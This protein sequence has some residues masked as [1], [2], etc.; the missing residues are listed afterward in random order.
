MDARAEERLPDGI[1]R[2]GRELS[3]PSGEGEAERACGSAGVERDRPRRGVLHREGELGGERADARPH[4]S[5]PLSESD[6]ARV[7]ATQKAMDER[8]AALAAPV[9]DSEKAKAAAFI[10]RLKVGS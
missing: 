6:R 8:A 7:L 10:A 3:G 4:R 1:A 9:P 5:T 2:D